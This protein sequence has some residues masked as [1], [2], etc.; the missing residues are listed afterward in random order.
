MGLI[1]VIRA[2]K[3]I[4]ILTRAGFRFVRQVGSHVHMEHVLDRSRKITIPRHNK[5]LPKKTLISILKQ[6]QI[7]LQEFLEM[8]G[9]I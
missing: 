7:T 8:I 3:L 2:V 9:R 5:D 1:P 6:A 4:S